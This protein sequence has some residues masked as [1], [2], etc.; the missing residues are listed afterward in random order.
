MEVPVNLTVTNAGQVL[1]DDV[2]ISIANVSGTVAPK[3]SDLYHLGTIGPGEQKTINLVLLTD[4]TA[5]PGLVQ[6]PVTIGYTT[7]DGIPTTKASGYRHDA[8]RQGGTGVRIG[9]HQPRP[10][11]QKTRRS[12]SRSGSRIPVPAMQNR[13]RQRST[14]RSKGQK[15]HSS[16]RS[17]RATMPLRSSSSRE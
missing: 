7:I 2:T 8:E 10:A 15:R 14:S 1:A 4:K 3:T 5:N 12:I 11:W 17:R 9:G 6:V 16:A 13:S